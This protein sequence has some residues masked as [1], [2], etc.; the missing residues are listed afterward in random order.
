MSDL[1]SAS[2]FAEK[3]GNR[4]TKGIAQE[5]R[6]LIRVGALPIGTKLPSIR[7]LAFVLGVSPATI[8]EAWSD[9]RRQKIITGR[10]RNGTF[11][12][13]DSFVAR[14]ERLASVGHY[15]RDVLDLSVASP[16]VALLPPL[17]PA[18]EHGARAE[19]LNSYE[20]SRILPELEDA[21]RRT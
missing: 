20:R 16:D 18:L 10:G 9:L 8:S 15:G 2:W 5:T 7:E 12:S 1:A 14:P 13:G 6:S 3:I 4:T 21:V 19:N 11:V 17:G